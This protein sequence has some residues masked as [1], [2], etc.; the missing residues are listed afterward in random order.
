MDDTPDDEVPAWFDE[1][2]LVLNPACP[3]CHGSG[4]MRA[5]DHALE[6]TCLLRQRVA[7]YLTPQYGS[8]INWAPRFQAA[9][10]LHKDVLIEN[11]ADLPIHH[12]RSLAFAAVKSFLLVTGRQFSHSTLRPY[13]VSH[14]LLDAKNPQTIADLSQRIQLL[15]LHLGGD[16]PYRDTYA[17]EL[18]WLIR[19]RR[20][21]GVVTWVIS[22]LPINGDVFAQRYAGVREPLQDC[23][24]GGFVSLTVPPARATSRRRNGGAT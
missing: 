15:V 6:C 11:T 10:Y 22:A 20:D 3:T 13:E 14:R 7:H 21:R 4:V 18:P 1:P 9:P 23:I 8:T 5:G 17:T 16:D 2:R 19:L 24:A 12:F